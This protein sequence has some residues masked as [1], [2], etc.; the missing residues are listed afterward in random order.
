MRFPLLPAFLITLL[1]GCSS[2]VPTASLAPEI[3]GSNETE[4][5]VGGE[6]AAPAAWPWMVGLLQAD[7]PD[8]FQAQFCGGTLI[9]ADYVLTAAHC[10]VEPRF[11]TVT[12]PS[13][14]EVLVGTNDLTRGGNR[15]PVAEVI[16]NPNYNDVTSDSDIALLR[17][18]RPVALPTIATA[19]PRDGD[20]SNLSATILG[21][22]NL[23][24]PVFGS[25]FPTQLQQAEVTIQSNSA[26]SR[27]YR[28]NNLIT[29]NMICAGDLFT[30]SCQGDSGGPL[31]VRVNGQLKQAGVT[32][33]GIGCGRPRFPGVYTRVSEFNTWINVNT[34]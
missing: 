12:A 25:R 31:V 4:L 10:L 20:L 7:N 9:E 28:G 6:T 19:Q 18:S 11:N 23:I 34:R 5:I 30:D 16:V 3:A 21:W 13:D 8:N 2:A 1:A 14:L 26:C 22:G 33:F 27:A 15:I 24:F 29:D 17:L 32:S